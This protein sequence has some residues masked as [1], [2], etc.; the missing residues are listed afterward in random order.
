MMDVSHTD[1]RLHMLQKYV[2]RIIVGSA[3]LIAAS[4]VIP[5]AKKALRPLA[6]DLSKQTKYWIV[7]AKEGMEDMVAE[8]KFE[9]IKKKLDKQTAIECEAEIETSCDERMYQ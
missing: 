5:I 4:A 3:L 7:S 1:W 9:R 2:Q 8:V 6:R